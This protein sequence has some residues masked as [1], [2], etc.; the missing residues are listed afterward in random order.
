[1]P[2]PAVKFG[3]AMARV[4]H[5]LPHFGFFGARDDAAK[6]AAESQHQKFLEWT[7]CMI[8]VKQKTMRGYLKLLALGI[9]YPAPFTSQAGL[10]SA[11]L[12]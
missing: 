7:V 6:A 10:P 5:K 3:G 4:P 11:L 2:P 9:S 8:S 12:H 1:M